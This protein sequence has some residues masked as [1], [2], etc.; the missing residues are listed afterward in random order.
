MF[1]LFKILWEIFVVRD[2]T[3][4]GRLKLKTWIIAFSFVAALY[5][6][7]VPAAVLWQNHPQYFPVFVAAMVLDGV[8]MIAMF[9]WTYR[10]WINLKRDQAAQA[11]AGSA[12]QS[13][14]DPRG[15]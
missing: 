7:G 15:A 5:A 6:T 1:E 9:V 11:A 8:L 12:A 10:T 13:G 2:A 14:G 3:R 4:K